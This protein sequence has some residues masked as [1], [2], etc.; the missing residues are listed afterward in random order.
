MNSAGTPRPILEAMARE[1]AAAAKDEKIMARLLELG[2]QP[3]GATLE[4][5]Q[6]EIDD[7]RPMFEEAVKAAGMKME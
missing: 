1:V 5:F 6:K 7:T 3:A 2:I 4:D